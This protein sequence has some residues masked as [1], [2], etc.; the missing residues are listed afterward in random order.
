MEE[1]CTSSKYDRFSNWYLKH[2]RFL[3]LEYRCQ[4]WMSERHW[5]RHGD[6]WSRMKSAKKQTFDK[7]EGVELE[8]KT[9][10]SHAAETAECFTAT[11]CLLECSKLFWFSLFTNYLVITLGLLMKN[12]TL[13]FSSCNIRFYKNQAGILILSL[14]DKTPKF[15]HWLARV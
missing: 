15:V 9:K 3:T 7:Y 2:F 14:Q 13:S 5:R 6:L 10:D 4:T 11:L 12:F 8:R 1:K